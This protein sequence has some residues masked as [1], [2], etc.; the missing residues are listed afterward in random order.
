MKNSYIYLHI[1][2][3]IYLLLI[4]NY[5]YNIKNLNVV[6]FPNDN[7]GSPK[8]NAHTLSSFVNLIIRNE[9]KMRGY[10]E[11]WLV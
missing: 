7:Q 4:S 10:D 5:N 6:N 2:L 8:H 9:V 1:I 11:L 3:C